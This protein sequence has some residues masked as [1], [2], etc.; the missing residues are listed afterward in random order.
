MIVSVVC[1][2]S[3]CLGQRRGIRLHRQSVMRSGPELIKILVALAAVL[4]ADEGVRGAFG[5]LSVGDLRRAG[6]LGIGGWRLATARR[7]GGNCQ[8]HPSKK[9]PLHR[10]S[11]GP[12]RR[13]SEEAAEHTAV[14]QPAVYHAANRRESG[15]G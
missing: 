2:V 12:A 15:R 4:G 1:G 3:F 10:E 8:G 6:G 9:R 13:Q 14:Q 11:T 7:Q 5:G